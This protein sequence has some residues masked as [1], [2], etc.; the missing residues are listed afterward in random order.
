M[1]R[2]EMSVDAERH[3]RRAVRELS[4]RLGHMALDFP[5]AD[6]IE[7]T[8][9][10]MGNESPATFNSYRKHYFTFFNR[11][12]SLKLI[13]D[14]PIS[15]LKP[16]RHQ[17]DN[18]KRILSPQNTAKLFAFALDHPVFKKILGRLALETFMGAR[19][20]SGY[21]FS[22]EDIN[23]EERGIMLPAEKLKEGME[24]GVSHY[25][26]T[27]N[28]PGLEILWDWLAITPDECWD[29]TP[30]QYMELKSQV[31]VAAGVPHPHN[32]LRKSFATYDLAAHRN[33]GRTAY[34]LAH[35]DEK[36]L[37]NDYKGNATTA[38][39]K[40]YQTISPSTCREIAAGAL[41]LG[42]NQPHTIQA[43]MGG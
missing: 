20:S 15:A 37:W 4:S 39:G 16:R 11:A 18:S 7:K 38:A 3:N 42:P 17:V 1:A 23:F 24:S 29:F 21:R 35:V 32:C 33:P 26:D 14:N 12:V 34:I 2:K 9:D 13:R 6:V 22:K 5:T 36:E 8:I 43:L 40:L 27:N 30:R 10:A 25:V 19:F 28:F 41:L 31:F